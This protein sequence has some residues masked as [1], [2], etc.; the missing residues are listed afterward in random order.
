[1]ADAPLAT[2]RADDSNLVA[3]GGKWWNVER[4]Y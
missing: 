4:P 1:M 2:L 3:V